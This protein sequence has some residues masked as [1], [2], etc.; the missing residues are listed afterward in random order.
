MCPDTEDSM[1]LADEEDTNNQSS[2]GGTAK[3]A[4]DREEPVDPTAD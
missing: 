4:T 2:S 3:T 1:E